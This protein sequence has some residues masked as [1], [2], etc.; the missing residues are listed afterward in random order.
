M[1]IECKDCKKKLGTILTGSMI[2]KKI[3]Y[4]CTECYDNY[5]TY[6]TLADTKFSNPTNSTNSTNSNSMPPGFEDLFKGFK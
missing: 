5:N 6:K 4:L 1:N 3:I 2:S